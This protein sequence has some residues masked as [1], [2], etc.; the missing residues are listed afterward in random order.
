MVRKGSPVRVRQRALEKPLE[1]AAFLVPLTA[2][3]ASTTARG[4][5]LGRILFVSEERHVGA[6]RFHTRATAASATRTSPTSGPGTPIS[7][8]PGPRPRAQRHEP[9]SASGCLSRE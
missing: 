2:D 1:T 6:L 7:R 3:T 9:A 8:P 5:L 4:P